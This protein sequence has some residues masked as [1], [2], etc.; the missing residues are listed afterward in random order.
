MAAIERSRHLPEP[1]MA[2]Q[3]ADHADHAYTYE[4]REPTYSGTPSGVAPHWAGVAG[5]DPA[6]RWHD[7]DA[8]VRAFIIAACARVPDATARGQ[9]T[10]RSRTTAGRWQAWLLQAGQDRTDAYYR[11]LALR[12][13][14]DVWPNITAG[15]ILEVAA[16]SYE[17]S[18]PADV[19]RRRRRW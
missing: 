11:F 15:E 1:G 10:K 17:S 12:S 13:A 6:M 19:K 2:A 18:Q 9:L 5:A 7:L 4:P 3:P 14:I 8:A 16:D